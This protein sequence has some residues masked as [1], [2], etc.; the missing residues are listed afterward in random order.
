MWLTFDACST[1]VI[2][3]ILL[4]SVRPG[5]IDT[6]CPAATTSKHFLSASASIGSR[7]FGG[8][9]ANSP[10]STPNHYTKGLGGKTEH[11]GRCRRYVVELTGRK[12]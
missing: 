10:Q 12:Q 6:I 4:P 8:C 5:Y 9:E 7:K 1:Q 2:H 3:K 11:E